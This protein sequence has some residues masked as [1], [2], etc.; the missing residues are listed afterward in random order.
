MKSEQEMELLIQDM[1][2]VELTMLFL[3]NALEAEKD[4]NKTPSDKEFKILPGCLQV[5]WETKEDDYTIEHSVTYFHSK[6]DAEEMKKFTELWKERREDVKDI[7]W[8]GQF[9]ISATR[10][11]ERNF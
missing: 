4:E 6:K 8:K 5:H 7:E 1:E 3:A 10:T 9:R 11:P 2:Q